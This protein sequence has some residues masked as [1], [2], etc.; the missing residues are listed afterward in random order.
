MCSWKNDEDEASADDGR[1]APQVDAARQH[2]E[3]DRR[4][5][6]HRDGGRDRPEQGRLKP[7]HRGD[8]GI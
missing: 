3:A 2:A 6:D 5:P 8:E 4:H 7:G 1:A